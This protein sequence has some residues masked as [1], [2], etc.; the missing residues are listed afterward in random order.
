MK[1]CNQA[2]P[3]AQDP[4]YECN[5][6]TGRWIK[7]RPQRSQRLNL[8]C[9]QANPKAQDPQYECNPRT[10][11]WIKRRQ[12]RYPPFNFSEEEWIDILNPLIPNHRQ[13][14]KRAILA[15]FNALMT[16][17][18]TWAQKCKRMEKE[19]PMDCDLETN[20]WCS[21]PDERGLF[22]WRHNGDVFCYRFDEIFQNLH[23]EFTA[24][25]TSYQIPPLRLKIPRD[26]YTRRFYTRE[27][28]DEFMATLQRQPTYRF[29]HNF[30]E[31]LYFLRYYREFF[32][33]Q[34]QFAHMSPV[35]MSQ[36]VEAF[37]NRYPELNLQRVNNGMEIQW[38]FRPR[39]RS[40]NIRHYLRL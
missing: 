23:R 13:M 31:V 36:Y 24:L 9:N 7:R 4:Q 25:D 27:F 33:Q 2:S 18:E 37:F 16:T 19:C 3:K 22:F 17:E 6:R 11:R 1:T 39:S 29:S 21:F 5:P 15:R 12:Q 8:T 14:S 38:I 28:F 26:T 32:T 10:G 35:A 30:P 20:E 40:R 34:H